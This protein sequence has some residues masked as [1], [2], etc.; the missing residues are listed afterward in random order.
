[1]DSLHVLAERAISK[2]RCDDVIQ[3]E[4][5]GNKVQNHV[6]VTVNSESDTVRSAFQALLD[7]LVQSN[8][9]IWKT[10]KIL[11]KKSH[12]LYVTNSMQDK[13]FFAISLAHLTGPNL[14]ESRATQLGDISP[15]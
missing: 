3:L 11:N 5:V 12:R 15:V 1:M 2:A 7:R 4:L 6:S 8:M 10:S 14:T 13:L 9:S